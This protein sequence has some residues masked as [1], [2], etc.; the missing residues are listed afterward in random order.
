MADLSPRQQNFPEKKKKKKS[1]HFL[2]PVAA[3][4]LFW[5]AVWAIFD[6]S[7]AYQFGILAFFTLCVF[8]LV[9]LFLTAGKK[10]K[11]HKGGKKGKQGRVFEVEFHDTD[12]EAP[13]DTRGYLRSIAMDRA[14][15]ARTRADIEAQLLSIEDSANKIV[16]YCELHPDQKHDSDR[17]LGYFLPT[18][19]KFTG[20]YVTLCRQG[21][22]GENITGTMREI[23]YAFRSMEEGFRKQLDSLFS[24]EALDISTDV[25]VLN[26]LLKKEGLA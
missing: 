6:L 13:L 5:C 11:K 18:L 23:E 24:E 4:A 20:M 1:G 26:A 8:L 19:K 14:V 15:I 17:F 9:R 12:A 7:H 16:E 2:A 22:E 25:S 21:I 10:E 3:A